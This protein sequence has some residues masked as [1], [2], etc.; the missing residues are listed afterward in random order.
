MLETLD[1]RFCPKVRANAYY[2]FEMLISVQMNL[3]FAYDCCL[4]C[5]STVYG[6]FYGALQISSAS[7]GKFRAACSGLKRI[8]SSLSTSSA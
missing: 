7:M 2:I 5:S 1:V 4:G 3:Y 8:Y 6:I